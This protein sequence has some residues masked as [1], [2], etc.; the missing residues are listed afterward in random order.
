MK[1][2]SKFAASLCLLW[3]LV[4]ASSAAYA[5]TFNVNAIVG[6]KTGSG[7]AG[8]Y[9]GATLTGTLDIDPVAGTLNSGSLTLQ[10]DPSPFNNF[11]GCPNSGQCTFTF[12]NG[13]AED[14]YIGLSNTGLVGY[15]GGAL[16]AGSFIDTSPGHIQQSLTG[17]VSP[18]SQVPEP[19]SLLLFG[20]GIAGMVS[21]VR[22]RLR[23]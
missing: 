22:R 18:V 6:D 20:S 17:T 8:P 4:L 13:F 23:K 15:S 9:T 10:G 12:T 21:A 14:G 1:S 16:L 7:G 19:G 5:D 3:A 11:F 2:I